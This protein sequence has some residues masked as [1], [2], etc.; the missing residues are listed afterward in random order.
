MVV[1][2]RSWFNRRM[3]SP[4]QVHL[5][6]QS[7]A[8]ISRYD[9]IAG[10][11]FYRRLFELDPSLRLF[12]VTDI[13]EQAKKLTDMLG[14]LISML[15]RPVGLDMELRAMG[16]RH[17]GYGVKDEHYGIV[18]AALF[19]MLGEVLGPSFT[20]EVKA[21]WVALYKEIE[22]TMKRGVA[23]LPLGASAIQPS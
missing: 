5:I 16:A 6:R 17:V 14:V 22:E 21:A 8:E 4:D 9:H 10:L 12:F 7:F 18:A 2:D 20:P 15:E 13:E 19:D 3:L 1:G 11:V 23:E